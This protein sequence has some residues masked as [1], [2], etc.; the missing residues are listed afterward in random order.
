VIEQLGCERA[1][2]FGLYN[3]TAWWYAASYLF[4]FFNR[5]EEQRARTYFVSYRARTVHDFIVW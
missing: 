3:P 1:C 2:E 5:T 4:F